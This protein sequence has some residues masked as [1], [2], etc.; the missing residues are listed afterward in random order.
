LPNG[1]GH[2]GPW[3]AASRNGN[4]VTIIGFEKVASKC[5]VTSTSGVLASFL[6]AGI[7]ICASASAA[8]PAVADAAVLTWAAPTTNVDGSALA[9]LIGFN[10]YHG[11]SPTAMMMAASLAATARSYA[12]SNLTPAVW[13]WYVTAVNAVGTESAPSAMVTKTIAVPALPAVSATAA[14]PAVAGAALSTQAPATA[15][16]SAYAPVSTADSNDA[17]GGVVEPRRSARWSARW[18]QGQHRTLC[19]PRGTVGCFAAR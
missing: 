13:Y 1:Q 4:Q 18:S 10:V 7:S 17:P 2:A 3:I 16:G 15:A 5:G 8:G 19:Q 14:P 12:E 6:M 11:T 9:D